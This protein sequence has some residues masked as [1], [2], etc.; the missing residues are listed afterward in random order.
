MYIIDFSEAVFCVYLTN[1]MA[2]SYKVTIVL[3]FY[4]LKKNGQWKNS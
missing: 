4:K 3:K 1:F 2:T